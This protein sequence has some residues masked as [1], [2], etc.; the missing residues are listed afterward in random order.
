MNEE[1]DPPILTSEV[2][3][4]IDSLKEGKLPGIYNVP[5][6]LLKTVQ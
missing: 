1:D 6:E 3:E 2:E 5:A 4:A